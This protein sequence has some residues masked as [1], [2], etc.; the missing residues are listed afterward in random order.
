MSE[1]INQEI[2]VE[3]RKLK[4]IFYAMLIC[5]ILAF[6]PAFYTGPTHDYS[7][8]W[9]RVTAAMRRQDFPAAL[10]MAQALVRQHPDYYY[11]HAYLGSI[12]LAMDDVTNAEAQYSR[13]FQLFPNEENQKELAAVQKRLGAG[14]GF[15]L[16]STTTLPN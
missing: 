5:F 7:N 10:S 12:Y 13:A 15:K 16:Q 6:I 9:E 3:L 14:A 8:S 4:R 2:L 11:G 1:D